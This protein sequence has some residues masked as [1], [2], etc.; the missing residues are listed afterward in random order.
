PKTQ[1]E[2][3]ECVH[4]LSGHTERV[5]GVTRLGRDRVASSSVDGTL[6]VW[7]LETGKVLHELLLPAP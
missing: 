7:S 5:T 4:V 3:G 2:L 6:R 1:E